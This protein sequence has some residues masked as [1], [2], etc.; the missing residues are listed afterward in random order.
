MTDEQRRAALYNLLLVKYRQLVTYGQGLLKMRDEANAP[1]VN[2]E[3]GRADLELKLLEATM[4][5]MRSGIP[6]QFPSGEQID[7]LRAAVAAMH[8]VL[9][10]NAAVNE[11]VAAADALIAAWPDFQL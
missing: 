2:I 11:V 9:E 6:I 3:L 4:T 8:D 5:A 7:K 10:Q 1:T